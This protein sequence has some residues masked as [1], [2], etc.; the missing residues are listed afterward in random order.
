[1]YDEMLSKLSIADIKEKGLRITGSEGYGVNKSAY[2]CRS[3][4][5]IRR[6]LGDGGD[7]GKVAVG[8][9]GGTG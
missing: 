1:M 6:G 2:S 7:R 5:K 9:R 4:T 8:G 3:R